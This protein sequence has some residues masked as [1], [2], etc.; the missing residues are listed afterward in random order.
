MKV[1]HSVHLMYEFI[2]Y[3]KKRI[4]YMY[5]TSFYDVNT[6]NASSSLRGKTYTYQFAAKIG[7]P[8]GA[9][10]AYNSFFLG[11]YGPPWGASPPLPTSLHFGT[12]FFIPYFGTK[13]V[14]ITFSLRPEEMLLGLTSQKIV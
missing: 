13:L 8:F 6:N 1:F 9:K 5:Q 4:L 10:G 2:H 3:S 11:K 14:S 7:A 12:Y